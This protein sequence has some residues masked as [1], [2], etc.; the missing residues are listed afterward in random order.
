MIAP[1]LSRY[2]A[3]YDDDQRRLEQLYQ[4]AQ[5]RDAAVSFM[6]SLAVL[7]IS[8]GV[9]EIGTTNRTAAETYATANDTQSRRLGSATLSVMMEHDH[10]QLAAAVAQQNS[11][12]YKQFALA[13]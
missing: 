6:G 8:G 1:E 12:A 9:L 2:P 11:L 7:T 5:K 10:S 13:A 4:A 3:D